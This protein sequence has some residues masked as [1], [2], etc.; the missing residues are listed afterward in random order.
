MQNIILAFPNRADVAS[1]SGGS[2]RAGKLPANLTDRDLSLV[3]R[4][5]NA[6]PASSQLV[7]ALDKGRQVRVLGL[8][9]HNLT[10]DAKYRARVSDAASFTNILYDSGWLDVW[11]AMWST[12]D[13]EWQ[14]ANWWS[15]R[16]TEEDIAKYPRHL[17]HVLPTPITGQYVWIELDDS[18]NPAGY[19]EA[20]RLVI[21]GQ[22]QPRWNKSWGYSF[23]VKSTT[24]MEETRVGARFYDISP[25]RRTFAFAL[26]WLDRQEAYTRSFELQREADIHG[27]ILLIPDADDSVN[28]YRT[29]FYATLAKLDPIRHPNL[30]Q[31]QHA[32]ELEEIL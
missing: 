4:S 9:G 16:P 1:F 23:G 24:Q 2:W 5:T 10:L 11:P 3:A 13:L 32:Y 12:K 19:I 27:E 18:I 6:T 28:L 25:N 21:A 26:D 14:D 29:A 7:A 30:A 31:C 17:I 20:T 15:G 8:L 22:W